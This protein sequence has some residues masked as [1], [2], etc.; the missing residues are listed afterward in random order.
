MT[1]SCQPYRDS[2]GCLIT[3]ECAAVAAQPA[4][5]SQAVVT[6]WNAGA[7]SIQMLD[8]DVFARFTVPAGVIGVRMGFKGARA[9]PTLPSL[10]THGFY[11][12]RGIH[13]QFQV[14]ENGAAKTT[15]GD[16]AESDVF[17]IRRVKGAVTYW[18]NGVLLYSSA[19]PSTGPVLVNAC[20]YQS[21]DGAPGGEEKQ[22]AARLAAPA[23]DISNP[24][25]QGELT[26]GVAQ[27]NVGSNPNNSGYTN[28]WYW[29]VYVPSGSTKL[30][31][32]LAGEGIAAF[33][34]TGAVGV[35]TKLPSAFQTAGDIDWF[36]QGDPIT[37]TVTPVTPGWYR[38]MLDVETGFTGFTLTAT[39]T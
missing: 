17:E 38:V 8:G 14:T 24:D 33:G 25:Y 7:N 4:Y 23:S 18:R 28:D 15:F 29:M 5:V 31:V 39:V 37:G 3:P 32:T 1:D 16:R 19:V 36:Y 34:E 20:L 27:T 12:Q 2:N 30:T 22:V 9:Q 11:F 21:G 35:T 6:G 10:I 26:S 13:D